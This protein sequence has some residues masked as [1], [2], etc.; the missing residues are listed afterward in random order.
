MFLLA[1]SLIPRSRIVP[2]VL[3]QSTPPVQTGFY[4]QRSGISFD[5]QSQEEPP[6][7]LPG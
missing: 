7:G 5:I 3:L 4:I 1:F 2:E 6:A